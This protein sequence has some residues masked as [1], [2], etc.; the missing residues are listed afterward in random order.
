MLAVLDDRPTRERAALG[1]SRRPPAPGRRTAIT[2]THFEDQRL[3]FR[4]AGMRASDNQAVTSVRLHRAIPPP[5]STPVIV[6]Q[7]D[8]RQQSP[9]RTIGRTLAPLAASTS[10]PSWTY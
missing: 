8:D 3:S 9:K 2:S 7:S 1:D 5:T 10:S 4:G 6:G